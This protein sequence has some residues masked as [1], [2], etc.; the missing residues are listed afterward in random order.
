[1]T[2][3]VLTKTVPDD[4]IQAFVNLER[5]PNFM[6]ILGWFRG[7]KTEEQ[8]SFASIAD[9]AELRRCQG[10]TQALSAILR[11]NDEAKQTLLNRIKK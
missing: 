7:A 5:D 9:D 8:E 11:M 1:M 4:V 2:N 6:R 3:W 10:R